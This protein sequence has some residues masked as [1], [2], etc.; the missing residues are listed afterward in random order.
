[1]DSAAQ[2]IIALKEK[3]QPQEKNEP[4]PQVDSVKIIETQTNQII[5]MVKK[6]GG[7]FTKTDRL[8]RLAKQTPESKK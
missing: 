2:E 7:S 6:A 8:A 1:M 5:E 3:V 4:A